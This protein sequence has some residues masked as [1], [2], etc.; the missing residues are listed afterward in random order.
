[1]QFLVSEEIFSLF[2]EACIGVVVAREVD[3]TRNV[4]EIADLLKDSSKRIY[5]KFKDASDYRSYSNI[6]VWRNAFKKC[7]IN[8]NRHPS[9]IE[10]LV[11]RVSRKPDFPSINPVVDLVNALALKHVLPM[12]AHD[13]DKLKGNLQ[14]RFSRKGDVFTPFGKK[15]H[16]EVEEGEIVYADDEEIRTRRWIWR[17]GEKAKI[18]SES[19]NIFFPIDGF[20][21]TTDNNVIKARDELAALLENFFGCETRKLF[22]DINNPQVEL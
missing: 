8:P 17:Q 21:G 20:H 13:M 5:Q 3:N 7:G 11:K 9:S 22:V 4:K 10:A 14:V 16:E 6:A 2:P 15:T 18:T 19:R 12:G 1:M